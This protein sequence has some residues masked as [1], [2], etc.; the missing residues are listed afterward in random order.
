MYA[1]GTLMYVMLSGALPFTQ[2]HSKAALCKE[3]EKGPSFQGERWGAVSPDA[4]ELNR[5]LLVYDPA[6]RP[7]AAQGLLFPWF[8]P[9]PSYPAPAPEAPSPPLAQGD[10]RIAERTFLNQAFDA[11]K[12]PETHLFDCGPRHPTLTTAKRALNIAAFQLQGQP[13]H[14]SVGD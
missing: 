4:I 10:E 6:R 12:P 13:Q 7:R 8:H 2:F 3:M 9:T 14:S 1:V 5:S 11:M